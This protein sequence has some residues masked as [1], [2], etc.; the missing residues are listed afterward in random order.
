MRDDQ[1][2][3]QLYTVRR[4]TAGDLEGTLR[5][6]REAG[7]R[8]VELAGLPDVEPGR[9]REMLDTAGLSVIGAHRSLEDL[10]T[11]L[12][13]TLAW[14][15]AVGSPRVIVPWLMPADRAVPVAV[16]RVTADLGRIADACADAG[17][18]LGYHNHDFEFQP[19]DGAT[20][21][22]V[23][24]AGLPASVELELDVY[25]ATFAG[26]DPVKLIDGLGGR[27]RLLHMK[28]MTAGPT[29]RD[30]PPGDGVLPWPAI[31]DAGRRA[32]VEWY[33]VEQD[34][35]LDPLKDVTR[36]LEHLKSLAAVGSA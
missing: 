5:H 24:V 33:V 19:A 8:A 32:G 31:V 21:W 15:S 3:L 16:R 12:D 1:I 28:D 14:L 27:V 7:Y 13:G 26:R 25:W 2:A 36:G 23:L 22:D 29:P 17:I 4:L 35:P 20:I 6:V 34:E 11:D 10:R 9:L 18:R 30:A